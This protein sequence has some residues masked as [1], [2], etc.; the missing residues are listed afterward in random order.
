MTNIAL[1]RY[2]AID[3]LGGI[4]LTGPQSIWDYSDTGPRIIFRGSFNGATDY[5]GHVR[6]SFPSP[7]FP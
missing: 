6:R 5:F 1:V 3:Y 4:F 7:V 2:G